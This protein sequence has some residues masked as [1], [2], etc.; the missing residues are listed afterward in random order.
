MTQDVKEVLGTAPAYQKASVEG[1]EYSAGTMVVTRDGLA[2]VE[3]IT[4][5][6]TSID[7]VVRPAASEFNAV[8]GAFEVCVA[9]ESITKVKVT[10][11]A[12]RHSLGLYKVHDR[13][14]CVPLHKLRGMGIE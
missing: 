1:F 10:Q 6:P 8:L 3:C 9:S 14:F 7:L 2:K 5:S 4:I 11:L 12:D 13:M